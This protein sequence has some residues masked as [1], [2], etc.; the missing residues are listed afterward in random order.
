MSYSTPL[1][2]AALQA[3]LLERIAPA[4]ALGLTVEAADS[5]GV[6]IAAPF[7][8][9]ANDKGTAFAGS[10]YS[11]AALAGWAL[12]MRLC[13]A[14]S[15][16]AEVML[17]SASSE[18][19]TPVRTAFRAVAREPQA[20]QL[21]RLTQMLQRSGRGRAPVAVEVFA[22]NDLA[23]TLAGVYAVVLKGGSDE[24]PHGKAPPPT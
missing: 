13:A 4:Q 10:L 22:G 12:L 23:M 6:T 18:F 14:R 21:A 15:L 9:N 24:Y 16:D 1:D 8:C 20:D 2:R 5:T 17:Q 19:L 3:Y 7:D 11:V